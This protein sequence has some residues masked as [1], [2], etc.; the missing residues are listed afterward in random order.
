MSIKSILIIIVIVGIFFFAH[1]LHAQ[2]GQV[3]M[4][5]FDFDDD[6][7][8]EIIRT[9]EQDGKTYIRI[10]KKLENS[11]FYAPFQDFAVPGRLV[12]VPEIHDVNKDGQMNYFFATGSDMGVL[13][14]DIIQER[15]IKTNQLD[16]DAF[17]VDSESSDLRR[18]ETDPSGLGEI[19]ENQRAVHD[20]DYELEELQTIFENKNVPPSMSRERPISDPVPKPEDEAGTP[21]RKR[22]DRH[23]A[24]VGRAIF[25]D[26]VSSNVI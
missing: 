18:I 4:A 5:A 1:M 14:F 12:Q 9:D 17:G 20:A 3:T 26:S 19:R 13:Y 7:Y 6:S 21:A 22:I 16:F 11:Y 10:Y 8:D 15:F 25:N 2:A 23:E 24:P